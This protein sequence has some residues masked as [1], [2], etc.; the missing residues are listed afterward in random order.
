[1]SGDWIEW[2]RWLQH[3]GGPAPCPPDIQVEVQGGD[4]RTLRAS[5]EIA[6]WYLVK[7]WRPAD[8]RYEF[9]FDGDQLV[10]YRLKEA[11]Q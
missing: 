9:K 2:E 7:R 10:A 11:S 3:D 8:D 6:P 1:M 4:A 5:A